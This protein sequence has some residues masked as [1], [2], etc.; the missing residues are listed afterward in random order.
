MIKLTYFLNRSNNAKI[1]EP[2][3]DCMFV[4]SKNDFLTE[5]GKNLVGVDMIEIAN[6]VYA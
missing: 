4:I 3:Q 2:P 1:N 5:N 6:S